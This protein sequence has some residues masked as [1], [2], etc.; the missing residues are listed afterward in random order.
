MSTAKEKLEN[1]EENKLNGENHDCSEDFLDNLLNFAQE[2][3]E[4]IFPKRPE[5]ERCRYLLMSCL[6]MFFL[7][8]IHSLQ[9]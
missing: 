9:L 8:K 5:C 1:L 7:F 6:D 3:T 2:E 4:S